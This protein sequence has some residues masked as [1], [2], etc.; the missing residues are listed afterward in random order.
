[1]KM[2]VRI[3][4][5][6]WSQVYEWHKSEEEDSIEITEGEWEELTELD[7]QRD[8]LEDKID[9]LVERIEN[10]NERNY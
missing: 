2:K 1:M 4:Q 5:T 7:R 8:T 9:R 3:Y 6:E 10:K